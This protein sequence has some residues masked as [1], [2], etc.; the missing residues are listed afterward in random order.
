[1]RFLLATLVLFSLLT[2]SLLAV[3][4]SPQKSQKANPNKWAIE[5]TEYGRLKGSSKG[6][7]VIRFYRKGEERKVEFSVTEVDSGEYDVFLTRKG[8]DRAHLGQVTYPGQPRLGLF[9]NSPH[10]ANIYGG[11][12]HGV[13]M[14]RKNPA[15]A[16]APTE[17][18]PPSPPTT[19]EPLDF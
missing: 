6:L 18:Q 14:V 5:R 8:G 17:P 4:S 10:F 12:W 1:M 19:D 11:Y 2:T 13:E 9:S 15:P 7:S 3:S 16:E